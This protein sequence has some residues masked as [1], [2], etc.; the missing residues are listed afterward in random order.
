MKTVLLFVA[1][2][3]LTTTFSYSKTINLETIPSDLTV[4][5][6]DNIVFKLKEN[7][8]T[9]FSWTINIQNPEDNEVLIKT[10]EAY[11][12]EKRNRTLVGVGGTIAYTIKAQNKGTATISGYY[13]RPWE[14]NTP[15]IKEYKINITV[16]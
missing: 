13:S 15:P 16:K 11:K 8:S 12:P 1:I 3:L 7:P 2:L 14:K 5:K 9:G 6:G 10:K 4:K